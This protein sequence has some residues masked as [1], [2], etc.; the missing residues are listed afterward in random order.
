MSE[1]ILN[2]HGQ[3]MGKKG[4]MTRRR[5]M[6]KVLELLG[7]FSYKDLTVAEVAYEANVSSSSFYVYF[8]DIEDVLYA[9]VIQAAQDMGGMLEILEEEWDLQNLRDQASRF[10][11]SYFELWEDHQLE[12]RI[13]NLEADQGNPRFHGIRI[14]SSEGVI[15]ELS[16]K[17]LQAHPK[18][19]NQVALATVFFTALE[20]NAAAASPQARTRG[21]LKRV[22]RKKISEAL[23]DVLYFMLSG[24][25]QKHI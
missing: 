18:I 25:S 13:R 16:R 6:E 15:L 12:L 8:A 7:S 5:I 1:A 22:T 20:R 4:L 3:K 11:E 2:Q 21:P 24:S 10:V 23:V 9:C 19:H 14:E 17:L